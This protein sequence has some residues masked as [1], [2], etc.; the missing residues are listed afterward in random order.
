MIPRSSF[1]F[2]LAPDDKSSM[3]YDAMRQRL[4]GTADDA[5][6]HRDGHSLRCI[7]PCLPLCTCSSFENARLADVKFKLSNKVRVA[8]YLSSLLE[9]SS[10]YLACFG[11][12][13]AAGALRIPPHA[14]EPSFSS[15]YE[16]VNVLGLGSVCPLGGPA[17][18]LG[19]TGWIEVLTA[20][21]SS[22]ISSTQELVV[23]GEV[24]ALH[25]TVPVNIK[26]LYAL[27]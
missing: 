11:F 24:V 27:W 19:R 8:R 15:F 12:A 23:I 25:R 5:Y 18:L 21:A 13:G 1:L 9:D 26:S 4:G 20:P 7:M 2:E 6:F 14:G 22:T 10:P 16:K 3:L 17:T